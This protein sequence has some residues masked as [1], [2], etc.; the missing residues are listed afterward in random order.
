MPSTTA[1]GEPARRRLAK[2]Q[3]RLKLEKA[4]RLVAGGASLTSAARELGVSPSTLRRWRR[5]IQDKT[6]ASTPPAHTTDG[7]T[8]DTQLREELAALRKRH[9]RLVLGVRYVLLALVLLVAGMV[10]WSPWNSAERTA[11]SA[12]TSYYSAQSTFLHCSRYAT[13]KTLIACYQTYD[14]SIA[15]I[16][17]PSAAQDTVQ[18]LQADIQAIDNSLS[19]GGD[20]SGAVAKEIADS[21][22][23]DTTLS[24]L[25]S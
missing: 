9:S 10:I 7:S 18:S 16:D 1:T 8:V 17:W 3:I 5:S 14:Q 6:A 15:A 23:L 21:Q 19:S 2:D 24:V 12:A 4:D 25:E 13:G 22:E 20:V 11:H